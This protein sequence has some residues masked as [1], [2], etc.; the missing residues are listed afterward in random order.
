V[1]KVLKQSY[2]IAPRKGELNDPPAGKEQKKSSKPDL[3]TPKTEKPQTVAPNRER[4]NTPQNQK[5]VSPLL[6]QGGQRE[7]PTTQGETSPHGSSV[8]TPPAGQGMNKPPMQG[9][10]RPPAQRR[11]LGD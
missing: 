9:T 11:E 4:M 8:I 2:V 6:A 5:E 10:T 7:G 1:F 3:V